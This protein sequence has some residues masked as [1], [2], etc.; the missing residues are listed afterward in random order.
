M[1]KLNDGNGG[2]PFFD[3]FRPCHP[4][5]AIVSQAWIAG[6]GLRYLI[7]AIVRKASM[8]W[9]AVGWYTKPF[10]LRLHFT[11]KFVSAVVV[12]RPIGRIVA[13]ATSQET[14][15][16]KQI[17]DTAGVAAAAKIGEILLEKMRLTEVSVVGFNLEKALQKTHQ[18]DHEK[19]RIITDILSR[20]GIK[21]I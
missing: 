11:N 17:G 4:K 9:S 13:A 2:I 16:R 7:W 21:F 18:R 5:S 10:V 20:N 8:G 15:L 6:C 1:R 19:I 14:Q 3:V 12:Q